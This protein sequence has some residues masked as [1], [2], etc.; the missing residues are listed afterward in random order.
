MDGMRTNE[1][2]DVLTERSLAEL[3]GISRE[4]AMAL[5]R[6]NRV[7]AMKVMRGRYL[8]S[9]RLLLEWVERGSR[10]P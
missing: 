4:S 2:P 8:V 10:L 3:L 1:V 9:K 5:C 6:A 7:P